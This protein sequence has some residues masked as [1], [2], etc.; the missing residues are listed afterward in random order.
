MRKGA[1]KKP[2]VASLRRRAEDHL[3]E[4][5]PDAGLAPDETDPKRLVHELQVHQIELETQNEELKRAREEVEEVLVLY[6]N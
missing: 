5:K 4:K 1:G 2:G 6:R 3:K